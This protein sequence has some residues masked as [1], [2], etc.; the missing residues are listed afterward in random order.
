MRR[1]D[2]AV[3]GTAARDD[4][5]SARRKLLELDRLLRKADLAA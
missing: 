1:E 2:D 3:K 4:F 5:T